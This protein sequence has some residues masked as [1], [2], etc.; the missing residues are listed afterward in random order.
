MSDPY[1]GDLTLLWLDLVH[2]TDLSRIY[3]YVL[4]AG[5]LD[6]YYVDEERSN[7]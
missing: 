3:R 5:P 2:M 7:G 6:A 1:R 4:S